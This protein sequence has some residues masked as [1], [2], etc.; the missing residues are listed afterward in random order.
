MTDAADAKATPQGQQ[1]P[2]P[3]EKAAKEFLSRPGLM[4]W[5][6]DAFM[7][8][9]TATIQAAIDE[10]MPKW[11]AIEAAPKDGTK[12][13]GRDDKGRV[14]DTWWGD[15]SGLYHPIFGKFKQSEWWRNCIGDEWFDPVEFIPMPHDAP[16]PPEDAR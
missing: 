16:Q 9:L 3:A 7:P 4:Y 14:S 6:Q 1:A 10:A 15:T 2:T 13:I 8:V 12:I 5:E 11:Q